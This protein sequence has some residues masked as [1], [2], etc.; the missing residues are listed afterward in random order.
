MISRFFHIATTLVLASS[1]ISSTC[2]LAEIKYKNPLGLLTPSYNIVTEDDLA[3]DAL[4]REIVP[5]DPKTALSALYWQCFSLKSAKARIESWRGTD[6]MGPANKIYDMCTIEIS[7]RD[8]AG[9]QFY[10]DHRG[11]RVKFCQQFLS[12][13]K[14]LTKNQ[15]LVCLNGDGGFYGP[16]KKLGKYKLWT[17]EKF[18]TLDGCYSYFADEC[19]TQGCAKG[20]GLCR[21]KKL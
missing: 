1:S 2:A 15:P 17:W 6:G 13:W 3:W 19:N 18:K 14:R 7:V 12:A 8:V 10:A 11:H 21:D 4:E 5:Y 20:K 16:D 9:L